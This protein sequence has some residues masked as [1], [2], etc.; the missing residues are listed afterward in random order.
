M[1][2]RRPLSGFWR[3]KRGVSAVEFALIAPVMIVMYC[4]LAEVTQAMMAQRRL[5]NIAS[6]IGDLVAQNG[7][8]GPTMMND[9]FT[10]GTIIMS[11]FPSAPLKMCVASITSDST[12]KDTVAWS[13][14]STSGMTTCPAQGTVLTNVPVGVLPASQSVIMTR[15]SYAYASP[16]KL[17]LPS[18]IT[19]QRTFYLRPRKVDAVIW[20]ASS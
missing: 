8:T 19:F 10:I 3:D 15:A 5:S 4:G 12:G 9:V 17:V 6:Q 16:I 7:Q 1:S 13:R 18:S 14:A 2:R 20:S 11:P